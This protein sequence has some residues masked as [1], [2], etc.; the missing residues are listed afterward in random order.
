MGYWFP[1]KGRGVLLGIYTTCTNIG[2]ISGLW[3]AQICSDVIGMSWMW[4]YIVASCIVAFMGLMYLLLMV[5]HP[6]LVGIDIKEFEDENFNDTQLLSSDF[7]TA[8]EEINQTQKEQHTTDVFVMPDNY[9]EEKVKEPPAR[10]VTFFSA[11]LIPGVAAYA[12][13]SFALKVNIFGIL[14]WFPTYSEG[15][16]EFGSADKALISTMYGVGCICGSIL[17]GLLSDFTYGKRGPV[18]FLSLIIATGC[19]A[20]LICLG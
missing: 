15:A 3:L 10:A 14:F 9:E 19:H 4:T 6:S 8:H 1:R 20:L 18:C 16:L 5:P 12:I 2:D 17:L 11:W 13:S 7:G